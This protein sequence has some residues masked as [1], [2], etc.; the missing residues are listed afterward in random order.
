MS[1]ITMVVEGAGRSR[2]AGGKLPHAERLVV[3][4]ELAKHWPHV[5]DISWSQLARGDHK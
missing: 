3:L 1:T 2:Q 5:A 4:V